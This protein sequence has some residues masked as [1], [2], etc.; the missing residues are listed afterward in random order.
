MGTQQL[1]LDSL[2]KTFNTHGAVK[3]IS[4]LAT[5]LFQQLYLKLSLSALMLPAYTKYNNYN[6]NDIVFKMSLILNLKE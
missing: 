3:F 1:L 4:D 5:V 6:G 2:L